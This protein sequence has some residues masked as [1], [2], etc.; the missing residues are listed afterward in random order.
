[1]FGSDR[2]GRG[3]FVRIVHQSYDVNVSLALGRWEV[4]I[5][6]RKSIN[7]AIARKGPWVDVS[8]V[9]ILHSGP[10]SCSRMPAH[11]FLSR[12]W[13]EQVKGCTYDSR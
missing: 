13:Y 11:A 5:E 6:V 8:L 9:S 10:M 3:E 4:D 7:Q 12:A 2:G 1:M